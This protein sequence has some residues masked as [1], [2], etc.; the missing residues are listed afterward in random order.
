MKIADPQPPNKRVQRTR[1]ARFARNSSPL[2]RHPLGNAG[3][4]GMRKVFVSLG[5]CLLLAAAFAPLQGGIGPVMTV[6]VEVRDTQGERLDGVTL[7]A[8]S[9]DREEV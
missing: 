8:K 7:S 6:A 3:G 4:T 5:L 1:V 9:L 2:T